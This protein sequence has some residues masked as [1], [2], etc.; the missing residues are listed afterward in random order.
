MLNLIGQPMHQVFLTCALIFGGPEKAAVVCSSSL[1]HYRVEPVDA[2]Q[3]REWRITVDESELQK[4]M[5]GLRRG[6]NAV[7]R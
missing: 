4:L 1:A 5:H 6:Q 3:G 7:D 2:E